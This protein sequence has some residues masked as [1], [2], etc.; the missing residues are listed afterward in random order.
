MS[1]PSMTAKHRDRVVAQFPDA[2]AKT[3]TIADYATG[4][5]SDV[6]DAYGKPIDVYQ[7]VFEQISLYI[8]VV[9]EKSA[10]K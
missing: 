4:K 5:P 2:A 7:Q 6:A 8:P 1:T 10:R 3:F 9:L